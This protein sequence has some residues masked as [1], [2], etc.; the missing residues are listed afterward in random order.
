[1]KDSVDI[2][3]LVKSLSM[4]EKRYISMSALAHKSDSTNYKLFRALDSM[5]VYDQTQLHKRLKS[6]AL[7]K[8]M[9][10]IKQNLHRFIMKSLRG[11][12]SNS[13]EAISMY[14]LLIE[15]VIMYDKRNVAEAKRALGKLEKLAKEQHNLDV[16]NLCYKYER[17][18]NISR[19]TAKSSQE[20]DRFNKMYAETVKQ[21]QVESYYH[22]LEDALQ[23]FYLRKGFIRKK[24]EQNYVR[25]FLQNPYMKDVRFAITPYAKEMYYNL[26][27]LCYLLLDQYSE[28][29]KNAEAE[30]KL[31]KKDI[32]N[33]ATRFYH[34]ITIYNN[35]VE[36]YMH[37]HKYKEACGFLNELRQLPSV[38]VKEKWPYKI[39]A[40]TLFTLEINCL[41][42]ESIIYFTTANFD[43]AL[44]TYALLEG[45]TSEMKFGQDG[46]AIELYTYY[47][48]YTHFILGNFKQTVAYLQ[49]V[50]KFGKDDNVYREDIYSYSKILQLI[51]H[52]EMG[53]EALSA[54]LL[55]ST[56]RFLVHKERI[57]PSEEAIISFIR[58]QLHRNY[59]PEMFND[60]L[61]K[62]KHKLEKIIQTRYERKILEYFDFIAWIDSKIQRK[63]FIDVMK[64]KYYVQL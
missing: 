11:F 53:D 2:F 43:K 54:Y 55:K 10:V 1:M 25:R 29:L 35:K 33:N 56:Y 24:S 23:E 13:N 42:M 41:Q 48:A 16:L 5:D 44:R 64:E 45:K 30:L 32:A 15:V 51:A 4:S 3:N 8:N 21:L 37:L 12:Y 28:A 59:K 50:L 34:Y 58:N 61:M 63:P 27:G 22:G 14:E 31:I 18:L 62:L 49:R 52:Y 46:F 26:K 40:Q 57:Y 20:L 38:A 60:N 7:V 36:M 39:P 17:K 9:A 6:E 19:L 47:N